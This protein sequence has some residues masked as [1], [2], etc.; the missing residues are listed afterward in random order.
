MGLIR[1]FVVA[2]ILYEEEAGILRRENVN[3]NNNDR[4]PANVNYD[5]SI[6]HHTAR[7]DD[8]GESV[9]RPTADPD[10]HVAAA[11]VLPRPRRVRRAR[12]QAWLD[13][14]NVINS[15]L[16]NAAAAAQ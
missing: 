2:W 4:H 16:R 5:P 11:D 1:F 3:N 6:R 13:I 12:N 8:D 15:R 9:Q 7:G 10:Q 14:N